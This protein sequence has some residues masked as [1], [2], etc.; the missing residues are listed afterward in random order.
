[1]KIAGDP[2]YTSLA[3]L[4]H[5]CKTNTK[6]VHSY[7][8]RGTQRQLGL[9]IRATAYSH[10]YP[11]T[12]F[13]RPSL[14]TLPN[15]KGT[16][17]VIN[18][19]RQAYDDQMIAFNNCNIIEHTIVQTINTA[20]DKDV[21]TNLINNSTGILV[22]TILEIM[23]KL[24]DMYGTVTPQLLTAAKSKLETT[25]YNHSRPIAY[26]FTAINDYA[27]MAEANGATETPVQII[28]IGLIAL[29][30]S[31]IFANKACIWQDLSDALNSCP[32]FKETIA[33]PIDPSNRSSPPSPRTL[34]ATTNK[35]MPTPS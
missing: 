28:N 13:I 8:G 3:R 14:T 19:A 18:S 30:R 23:A 1:M 4:K 7:L 5:E 33:P 31:S 17:T 29:T 21:L 35:P 10:I 25:T 2:T 20:L 26:Q 34:L 6:S 22:G 9:V 12:P 16:A 24:Y 11:G 27:N 15:T 32:T